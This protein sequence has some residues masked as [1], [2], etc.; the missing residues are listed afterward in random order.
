VANQS[1]PPLPPKP[2]R[3]N[4][5]TLAPVGGTPTMPK[6]G[7]RNGATGFAANRPP[8]PPKKPL[9]LLLPPPKSAHWMSAS[10]PTTK[11]EPGVNW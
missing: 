2:P 10:T 7:V 4:T 11:P 1:L 5:A 6:P 8:L 3:L 9:L